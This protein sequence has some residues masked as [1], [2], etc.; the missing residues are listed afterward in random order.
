MVI[1]TEEKASK[2]STELKREYVLLKA[3]LYIAGVKKIPV[4]VISLPQG[5]YTV[6][7]RHAT[8]CRLQIHVKKAA[9]LW[10]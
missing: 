3:I 10:E 2:T 5:K 6:K 7:R 4:S 9:S 8:A 1:A